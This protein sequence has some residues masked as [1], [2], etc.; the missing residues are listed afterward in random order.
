MVR[1]NLTNNHNRI[2]IRFQYRGQIYNISRLG[3]YSN[4]LDLALASTIA[5]KIELD[6]QLGQFDTTLAKYVGSKSFRSS[7]GLLELWDLWV[8]T[9]G[10]SEQTKSDHY[11]R[12]RR[13][14]EK[15]SP[16]VDDATWLNK[17]GELLAPSTFN[18][19]LRFY[20]NC[21]EWAISEGLAKE[22]PYSKIKPRKGTKNKTKPLTS[23]EIAKILEGFSS[24]YP[25]YLPFVTF[26]FLTGC[27]ISEAIGFQWKRVDFAKGEVTIADTL[28]KVNFQKEKLRKPTKTSAITVLPMSESLRFLLESLKPG[29]SN[30]LVFTDEDGQEFNL[31]KYHKKWSKVLKKAEIPHV[32]AYVT[33]HTLASH[34]IEQGMSLASVAYL[35]GHKS[36]AMVE[37]NYVGLVG[38]A[39]LPT[40]N[41]EL[42]L[43][44]S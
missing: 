13:M 42:P 30:D 18:T 29:K 38:N 37:R 33:R 6:I 34:A 9:L 8:D 16:K 17:A 36:I 4:R 2:R 10:L 35:L 43:E 24:D 15:H 1:I 7:I 14:I 40:I 28:A 21:L 26:L 32:K 25:D 3:K 20:R 44:K 5:A 11:H 23:K 19:R 22:N 41:L 12:A 27:R 31:R 39:K